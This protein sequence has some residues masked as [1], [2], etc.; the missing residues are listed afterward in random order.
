MKLEL[1]NV[2]DRR[3]LACRALHKYMYVAGLT[4]KYY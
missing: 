4:F 1:V 3:G 2:V